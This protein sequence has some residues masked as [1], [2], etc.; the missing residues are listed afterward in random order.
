MKLCGW[1]KNSAIGL[2][3]AKIKMANQFTEDEFLDLLSQKD[4]GASIKV[5]FVDSWGHKDFIEAEDW[6]GAEW[7]YAYSGPESLRCFATNGFSDQICFNLQ[8]GSIWIVLHR[9][10]FHR[11]ISDSLDEFFETWQST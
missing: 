4:A 9:Y 10:R 11:K 8:D 2:G 1:L 3:V 6:L 5:E 7:D